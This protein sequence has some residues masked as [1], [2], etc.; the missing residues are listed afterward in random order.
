MRR[1]QLEEFKEIA[2]AATKEALRS[3]HISEK[4][5]ASL[6]LGTTFE[7]DTI[8]FELYIPADRPE[9]GR[10]VSEARVSKETGEVSVL[11]FGLEQIERDRD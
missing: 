4:V 5:R 9:N 7:R 10:V 6:V 11:V 3:Y 2:R 8:V 1:G